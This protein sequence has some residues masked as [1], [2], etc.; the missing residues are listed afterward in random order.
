MIFANHAHIYPTQLREDGD[1]DA[2]KKLMETCGIDR[3]V[4]FA[5]FPEK[6]AELG[7]NINN[8]VWLS[9]QIKHDPAFTGFGT[10]DFR[11]DNL[12]EQVELVASLGFKGI[13]LHPPAQGFAVLDD[14]A[15]RVYDR[16]QSLNLFLSFHT[17]LHWSRLKDNLPILYDEI[18]FN[19]PELRLSME[20]IGGYSFF[21]DALAVLA[22][23]KRGGRQPRVF[24]GW[25]SIDSID[26][27]AWTLTDAQL[28][29]VIAQ[30]GEEKSIFGLDF[31]F[32]DASYITS[33]IN[34]INALNI[35]D[36][37]KK[38]ILGG[39]LLREIG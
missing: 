2:L 15:L 33:S 35:T 11:Q 10:I 39:N 23:H 16:A 7:L 4:A 21:N 5:T 3:C 36:T 1:L 20:H 18:A 37:A 22:N 38:K 31:P 6:F 25:T 29:T 12:E 19:F 27:S 17:G 8:N 34:R 32:K 26:G 28:E 24:A 30:T 9:E 13:K 14:K